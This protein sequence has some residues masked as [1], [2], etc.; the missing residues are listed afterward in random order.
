MRIVFLAL[1]IFLTGCSGKQMREEFVR[2]SVEDVKTSAHNYTREVDLGPYASYEKTKEVIKSLNGSIRYEDYLKLFI[3]GENFDTA[4]TNCT[5][6]TQVGIVITA[7]S[8]NRS[9]VTLYSGNYYLGNFVFTKLIE[10]LK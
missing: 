1:L 5:N 9:K 3:I 7:I 8:E 4:F 6:T 10:N 2:L